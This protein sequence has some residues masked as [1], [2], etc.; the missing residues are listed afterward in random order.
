MQEEKQ[1]MQ[2]KKFNLMNASNPIEV[3][4]RSVPPP[5]QEMVVIHRTGLGINLMAKDPDASSDDENDS[6]EVKA[7][8]VESR[9]PY[10]DEGHSYGNSI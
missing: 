1:T 8:Q 2:G 4:Y 7:R 9:N 10:Q 6:K 5:Q 3:E